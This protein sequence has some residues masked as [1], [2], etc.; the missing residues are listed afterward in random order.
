MRDFPDMASENEPL[1]SPPASETKKPR[2]RPRQSASETQRQR[3]ERLQG[4]LKQAQ[5]ALRETEEKRASIVGHAALRH[6]SHNTEFARLLASA[7][8]AEIKSKAD[9]AVVA[10]L[11]ADTQSPAPRPD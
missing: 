1:P 6:A 8:H 3:I 10:D 4:E 9:R 5:T 11:L 2:G 7:L